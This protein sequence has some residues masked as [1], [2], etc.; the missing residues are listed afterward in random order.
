[1]R[2]DKVAIA[3]FNHYFKERVVI[4]NDTRFAEQWDKN[5]T[6][7]TGGT[8]DA[9]IDAPEAWDISTGGTTVFG[10]TIVVAIVDGGQQ[11]DHQDLNTWRNWAEIPANGIDDDNN[12]YIDDIQLAGMPEAT[13]EQFLPIS[14]VHTAQGLQEQKE[15]IIS[16]LLE[17]T[18][19]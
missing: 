3:Q 13:T 4:P 8:P 7:Q 18:G 10:D 1:M 16:A 9:D 12:G 17:S 19:M 2:S 6:G 5:N 11:I 14:T 15:I